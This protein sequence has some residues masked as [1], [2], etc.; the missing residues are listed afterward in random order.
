MGFQ[1][2]LSLCL[3]IAV[4]G[5]LGGANPLGTDFITTF[6]QNAFTSYTQPKQELRITSHHDNTS[7]F[8]NS[9]D[10]GFS[11]NLVI[12][13]RRTVSIQL[14]PSVEIRGS[15]TFSNTVRITS[16]KPI[17]VLT[18]NYRSYSGETSIVYPLATL[19]TEYYLM[20]PKDGHLGSQKVFSVLASKEETSVAIHLKGGLTYQNKNYEPNSVFTVVLKPF[21]GI[22][23]LSS[24]DLS[25]SRVTSQKPVAVLCGHTCAKMNSQ[26]SLVYEQ[27]LPVSR[28]GTAFF[29]VPLSFQV[30]TDLV[31]VTAAGP[32]QM[33]YAQGASENKIDLV[34]GQVIQIEISNVALRLTAS[35]GV[36]VTFF[37]KGG[38]VQRSNY[39][40]MLMNI[41]DIQSY[42]SSYFIY[43]QSDTDNYAIVIAKKTSVHG[44][45]FDGESPNVLQYNPIQGTDYVWYEY[46]Y[47]NALTS[48]SV[49]HSNVSFGLQSVGIGSFF[50]Y[51]SP[52]TCVKAPEFLSTTVP[53]T[54]TPAL[55]SCSSITCPLRQECIMERGLPKCVALKVNLCSASGDPHYR[56][57][58]GAYYDFMGTCTYTLVT[59]CGKVG[60]ALPKFTVLTKNE[61][62][63]NVRVSYVGQVTFLVDDH[64]IDVKKSETGYVRVDKSR[65]LLPVSLINGTL[66]IFQSGNTAVIQYG[67]DIQVSYDWNHV[68]IVELSLRYAK[69]VCG[70][71]GNYN[72]NRSDEFQTPAGSQTNSVVEFGKSWKVEDNT[73][74]WDDCHGPCLSCPPNIAQKYTTDEYC[75]LIGKAD[76]PFS[77]CH[78]T[79]DPKMYLENCVYDVCFNDGYKQFSCRALKAYADT[80]QRQGVNISQ[81]RE[82]AG[83]PLSCPSNS[84]YNF[85]GRACPATCQD[86][87]AS[88][89]CTA[90][91]IEA[92]E[93]NPGYVLIEGKCLPVESCGCFFEGRSY[94][95]NETFWR[96]T[97]CQMKCTCNGR[98]QRVLCKETSCRLGEECTVKD[99]LRDCYPTSFGTCTASGDP[100]YFTFD[101]LQYD[102]Q[103]T[104]Q[105][106]LSALCDH[107]RGLTDFQV[108]VENQNRGDFSVSY[109]SNVYV[110]VYGTEI[111]IRMQQPHQVMIDGSLKHLLYS[112]TDGRISLYQNPSSAV[113]STDFGLT[114]TYDWYSVVTVSVPGTYSGAVCGLC[115]NFNKD[116]KD[117]LTSR[118]GSVSKSAI[119]IAQTWKVGGTAGC[120]EG[121]NPICVGLEELQKKQRNGNTECGVLLGRKGPFRD[122]HRLVNPEPYFES[123]VYDYCI[124]QSRQTVFCSVLSS[125]AQ[126]CQ[127]A[128]GTVYPWRNEYF[129]SYL[130]PANSHYEVCG[131]A[132][133]VTCKDLISPV[134]CKST[135]REGCVCDAGFVLSGG[136]CVPISQCG[137]VYGGFYH[138]VGENIYTGEKCEQRCTC[139]QGGHMICS[140]SSCSINEE[141]RRENGVLGCY[142]VGSAICSAS[143]DPHYRT[144][145][146]RAY[147]F[148]GV[149][150]YVLAQSCG[151]NVSETERNLTEFVVIT[152]N[153]HFGISA[154]VVSLVTVKVYGQT[155]T[156]KQNQG[157]VVQVN[158]ADANLPVT[159]LSGKILVHFYGQGALIMTDFGLVVT[160][161]LSYHTTVTVPGNYRNQ[162]C[163]LCGNYDGNPRNDVGLTS[164]DIIAFGERWKTE[165][166]CE[167]G[168]GS[169]EN[170]CPTCPGA[171]MKVFSQNNYCGI[172]NSSTGPFAQC[173][174]VVD[175]APFLKDCIFDLCQAN[176][177]T[178]MLCNNVAVYAAAC[179]EA[180]VR[181]ITWRTESF[182]AMKCSAHSHY[183][184]CADLCSSSCAS[185]SGSYHCP[186]LCE[187]G[188]ECD[189]GYLFDGTR[190]VP[191]QECGCYQNGRYYKPNETVFNENCSSACTCNPMSGL[192]CRN[193][194]C[195]EEESCQIVGG[196]RAC[197]NIATTPALPSCSSITC[198]PRQE[199]IMERGGPKCVPIK[200]N[201]CLASG[202]PHYRT[203]DGRYYDFMG[204]C[205]YTLVTVCEKF[206]GALPNFTVLT[207]NENR[208]NLQ[209]SIVGQVTFQVNDHVIDVKNSETG[210]VRVDKSRSLLPVSLI[211]GTLRIFQSG[212]TAVIQYGNDIQVSYDWNHV[213]IVEL[214][215]RYA[216]AV[217]GM[218]G[219]YNQNPLD[220][221]QTHNGSQA[222]G[223]VDFGKSWKVEDNTTCWDDCHGQCLSCPPNIAEKYKSDEY[224]GLINKPG[225]PFSECHSVVDPKM[226]SEN[227]VYD[228]CFNDGYKQ[229]SCRALKAFADT[230]QRQGVNI[231]QWRE[232][233]GCPFSCPSNSKYNFCGRACPATCQDPDASL[234]CTAPCIEACECNPGYVLIEGKCLPVES[235]GCFFEGRSYSAN[236][237]FWRDTKCQ[238]KC[239]CNGRNQR[240]VCKETSCRL[241]EEC[242][243]KGGLRDCYPT[244]FGTCTAS[245]DPHYFTFDGLQYDFQG[246]CQYQLSALCNHSRGLTD[247]QVNVENQNRGD[248]RYSFATNVFVKVYSTEI[249]ISMQ[250]PHQVMIGGSLKYLP[251]SSSDGHISLYQNPSSAVLSTDFGLTVTFDWDSIV[252]VTIPGTYSGAV[253]GLCG[254]FN[255][256]TKDDLTSRNGSVSESAIAIA[257]TWKVGG[258]AGCS[259]GG[260]PICV[261]LDELR[262]KQRNGNTECG[263]LLGRGGPFRD[264]HR[265][266]NPEPYFESCVYDYC[267]LQSRQT[268]FCSVLSSYAQACQ[269][270]GGT[271]Y[272]WRNKD[273]CNY[274]CPANSHYEVCGNACPVTCKDLISPV[275]CKSTCREGCVCD[276]GFVL[277]GGSCVP[278]S[279][280]GCVYG[281]FY[282]P[283]GEN[284]Y[285]GEKCEQR[286]T[287]SQGGHMI[288]SPSSCSINEECRQENG[289]LGCYPVGSAICSASGD[290]HYRTFDGRAY[291]FQGVC[292]YVLAQSCGGNVSETERN[293]TEFV[294]IT[295]NDHFGISAS[296]VSLVTVKVYGQTLTL[297]QNQGGVV[298]INGAD[299]SLPVTLLSGKILVHFY[300]QGAVI[301]TDFGLVVT[302]DLSYHTTVTVPGNYRNQTCGLCGN[303]DDNSM[304]DVGLT[305]NDIIAFGE[306]WKTEENCEA[307][308]GSVENPCPTCQGAKMKVF[309]QINYCGILNS[310][311]GPFAQ[312]HSVVDPAPFLKDCIFDLCQANGDT[313][314]LCNN[315]AVYAAACKEA[316][317]RN[318]TWRTES[319]CDMKCSA[320]SHYSPC[321]DLCVSSCAS[322]SGSYHCPSLCEEGCECDRGYLFD[323]TRCVPLQECGCY[324][325]GRYYKPNETVL[326]ENCSSVC[327]CNPISGLFCRNT[328]CN[329]D[330]RCQIVDGVR[331]CINIDP[332][333]SKTCRPM[334]TCKVQDG[335]AVCLSNLIGTCIAWGDPH[336]V[337]FDSYN[338]DFQGTCTYT[339][340]NYMGRDSSLVPF[341]IVAKND[342]RGSQ[343]V[344]Y[345]RLINVMIYERNISIRVGEV[346]KIH[347]D[348]I[349][350]NLPFTLRDGKV[351]VSQSGSSAVLETDFGLVVKYDWNW[352][353]T[354]NLPSSYHNSVSGLCG[355]FN[356]NR[357][358]ELISPNNTQMT[359]INEWAGSWKVDD[360]D[361]FCWDYCSGNCKRCEESKK[362]Q[363]ESEAFCG[364]ILREDGPFRDCIK[365]VSPKNFFDSCVYD[366]CLNDGAQV[367]L[368]Q[369]LDVYASTCLKHGINISDWRT[370]SSCPK[371]CGENSHYEACG[372]SCPATCSERNAPKQCKKPC[373][374]T[375]QCNENF[376]LSVDKCVPISRCGCNFKG[377]YYEPNQEFWADKC[378]ENC[379]CDPI[380]GMVVCR[381]ASCKVS[382][383]CKVVNGKYGCYPKQ[384]TTC[385][386]SNDPHY[387]TF[388][389]HRFNFMGTCIYQMVGVVS[390]D[391]TLT[392]FT[393][394]VQNDNRGNKAVSH[395]KDVILEVYNYTISMS[396]DFPRK[397]KVNGILTELPYYYETTK[398]IAYIS[399]GHVFVKTDFDVTVTFD[400]NSYARV[401]LPSTYVGAVN[402]L[403]GNNN[404]NPLDDFTVGEGMVA[405]TADEFGNHWKVG[406]V[407]GCSNDC[408]ECPKCTQRELEP[409]RSEKYCGL[410]SSINGPFSRCHAVIDPK[411]YFEDCVFDTCQY[412]G[413]QTSYCN[414]IASYVF[415]CQRKGVNIINW[416]TPS[417]CPMS[418]PS[419]SHYELCGNGCPSTCHGLTSPRSCEKTC[420]EGCYCDSGFLL[421]GKECVPIAQC[422]CV[423]NEKYYKSGEEF[424][425]DGQC[426]KKCKCSNNGE[427]ICQSN[428]CGPNEECSVV[429]GVLGCHASH[430]G[431]CTASGDPHYLTFDGVRYDFQGTCTY[432]LVRVDTNST[433]FSVTVDHEPFG[434][435][436]VA[437][438]KSVTVATG[439]L[440]I[441]LERGGLGSIVVNNERHNLPYRSTDGQ[442]WLNQEGNNVILQSKIG[443]RLLFD[444]I[445]FVSVWV[446]SS[447]AGITQGL[448]GNFNSNMSDDFQL[449]NGS[450]AI[451]PDHFG[452]SW[453]VAKDGSSCG[454]CSAG[455]CPVCDPL[456]K[457]LANS[458]SKCGLLADPKGPFRGC[459][460]LLPPGGHV[461]NCVY[462]V[463]AGNGG[464][465]VLCMSL[466]AYAA[467]CQSMGALLGTWR[468]AT[469]C[470]LECPVN[471]HYELC[472][473]TCDT[474]CYGISAPSSC[475]DKCFEGCECDAGY[476]FDGHRC[477]SLNNCGC[478][479]KGRYLKADESFISEGCQQNCTCQGGLVS[480]TESNCSANEICQLRDG[481]RGCYSLDSE[482]T[483]SQQLHFTT[484]DGVSG[485]FPQEGAFILASSCNQTTD[486]KFMV[487]MVGSKCTGGIKRGTALH[488][489][490]PQG[491]ITVNGKREC[492]LNGWKVQPPTVIGNNSVQV[493]VSNGKV[494]ISIVDHITVVLGEEGEVTLIAKEKISGEI[495]GACGNFNRVAIDDLVLNNGHAASS[496]THAIQ[497][498][499]ASHFSTCPS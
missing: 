68:V 268:V 14:F 152:K 334:E 118:N 260:N 267:M 73:T 326:H 305:S 480:C 395:T 142:P 427:V 229:F 329:K 111:Q 473:R 198:P 199:C 355:N 492:W 54:T 387:T 280:C 46:Y 117:D 383:T 162:T 42:C 106:Q 469:N 386:A 439:D 333:K 81:W 428:Q 379:K 351:K 3:G 159:L 134:G 338:F 315:V 256:D 460:A 104:C 140:P 62:R 416:R 430:F 323:G 394:N 401:I 413:H 369:A 55:P 250:Q 74:C 202:D 277:S 136:S 223:V 490:I 403:C 442:A 147:D 237:T 456:Q 188:C 149:C 214:S 420:T 128:G 227:C 483:I 419:Y 433:T 300:G 377:Q 443:L 201:I 38:R 86:P 459:H 374:E 253:C 173:H 357:S 215:L 89:L 1:G 352:Y 408:P 127:S 96:D 79:V 185:L 102:F 349:L 429:Q 151:G 271:V 310:S 382:E 259:E 24:D 319:F 372:N 121:G 192:L 425:P 496:M 479:Y 347:V 71:C 120:S 90:P 391:S 406:E 183:S 78:S 2:I 97:K 212:D 282:H 454:G 414:N 392:S 187:E 52:G 119:A 105:Y 232:A 19:G 100:H 172:L 48:R 359:S 285:T 88:L 440:T 272:P 487:T 130:C 341:H 471:S 494:T 56:T 92:C 91:C 312:C 131:N 207:K 9:S 273:F 165:E 5:G 184:P 6:L 50:S 461:E 23:L 4:F 191:L 301:M 116:T 340:V 304:N 264:C 332:C 94:S 45:L 289:V 84:K 175:P 221:F 295:K 129:C 249:H 72:Q 213:V 170:P 217:C 164:N 36:Q 397:I 218:C 365:N 317:V 257:Q 498:W 251:Y 132:C 178:V 444:R 44:I 22:Q 65:S 241:G 320:H 491:L 303:Y 47:G 404:Q 499:T 366:V 278:I 245:G 294:V 179:K 197:I 39:S 484:F 40:P 451:Y 458:P 309:S 67:N 318:I 204:T 21:Q 109:A 400:G 358:D 123:C 126:A 93:C 206:G 49:L 154:S 150:H 449:P 409:Y 368:C 455:Q 76:G 133:P 399:G 115:G 224:C 361:Q 177:D 431:Q 190:C 235:C 11:R 59:V 180:G 181:N 69:A 244:S 313:V 350:T 370:P 270:A 103:G 64:V 252:T 263:V 346:G 113:L 195:N 70:M 66:R 327:T 363:Y 407:P 18:L 488:V 82:A 265:L 110:K 141:C 438:T 168:C 258:T 143:G 246:T 156:L 321:A 422:G 193:T 330:E 80:C 275:G 41:M 453:A 476:V 51:G 290:P 436:N 35:A 274:L 322:L 174:S 478:A 205:T 281:G 58:D 28:W 33:T 418:C 163:G 423:F 254:N 298:Q 477:V 432:I 362:R 34:A 412:K 446:P 389:R 344:S 457:K 342:N 228:V 448:C 437:V 470:T 485:A 12:N 108:N 145:D 385:T 364:L 481:L 233:A 353:L 208:G 15:V 426:Q 262:K 209:V 255:K 284:I 287:C 388:D 411:P 336:Y 25:G 297:K 7:V 125:Y 107:S 248:F 95:A 243:V 288:C 302:Y 441:R 286:C 43:G 308:C 101:G 122:C 495:C 345:V 489:F 337:T 114:V 203:F 238:M 153:D 466:Q 421:S 434:N 292:H 166:N 98:N 279:Q 266:V 393:V 291:D 211:N 112:S 182:C 171:E 189:R 293:L 247:F 220:D 424:Y 373:V 360:G 20:T 497:S 10:G 435:R 493:L 486:K 474:T 160:Y 356:G 296:V 176:G 155:L 137:C 452:S 138:P 200:V 447:F 167:A 87:D 219:N 467:E 146:G 335:K 475:T 415:E 135:C 144:F 375:C 8:I 31:F 384:Y 463:C 225:G 53:P 371:K 339:L 390:N 380:L 239:T 139:S 343:S 37:F 26:C 276:A 405:K 99:G 314:M 482:C 63:G 306:R 194:S 61:N 398:I 75:G 269:S 83:C 331:S 376:V 169:V 410:L 242:T 396:K 57:F 402:G 158:G 210:Y 354:I 324:Q 13:S 161:D 186:S 32:T 230:C 381:Q 124:L 148:Q 325:N 283:V 231:S 378:G 468:N 16:N 465:D 417:F 299:A 464:K 29:V 462:D 60:S 261:G 348:G 85:C 367:I 77:K 157:G 17:N 316:G 234:L 27:L 445:Y 328:A 196:V 307:G 311:T 236:E 222:N 30:K 216:E 226:Y 450:L 240:V 472:T